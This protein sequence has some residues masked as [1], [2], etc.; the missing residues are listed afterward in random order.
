MN[1]G[2]RMAAGEEST[3]KDNQKQRELKKLE[4]VYPRDSHIPAEYVKY[5]IY[6]ESLAQY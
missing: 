3:E 6:R 5:H 1:S 4:A 2:W